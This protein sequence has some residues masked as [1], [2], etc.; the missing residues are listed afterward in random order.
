MFPSKKPIAMPGSYNASRY[1]YF[2]G[3]FPPKVTQGLAA[4]A[5]L[6]RIRSKH[7]D[8]IAEPFEAAIKK[9]ASDTCA[10]DPSGLSVVTLRRFVGA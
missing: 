6:G 4:E 7:G 9:L 8:A 5:V 3:Y 2:E 1:K 10:K